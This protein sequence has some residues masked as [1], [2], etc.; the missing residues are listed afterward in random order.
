[1]SIISALNVLH[2]RRSEMSH[3][4]FCCVDRWWIFFSVVSLRVTLKPRLHVLKKI[5]WRNYTSAASSNVAGA[6]LKLIRC[7]IRYRRGT[8]LAYR[9]FVDTTGHIR[10]LYTTTLCHGVAISK[11]ANDAQKHEI[12]N[13][14]K[15]YISGIGALLNCLRDTR[16]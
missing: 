7:S 1:M 12:Y 11:P 8:G 16:V 3:L 13:H 14:Q 4:L 2:R 15:P 6:R 10:F 5:S 9:P